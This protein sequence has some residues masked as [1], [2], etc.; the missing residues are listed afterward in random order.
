MVWSVLFK[1]VM[2]QYLIDGLRLE[3]YQKLKK[4]FN[5]H[6]KASPFGTIFWIELD[7]DILTDLQ[8]EHKAC[9]P[10]VFAAE[11][12]E[13]YLSCELLVRITKNIKCDCMGY[14]TVQQ[15]NWLIEKVDAILEELEVS[16]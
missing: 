14:A 6:F 16:I 2:K 11:L 12:E 1:S 3:D 15:R 13:E 4:Y 8:K 7:R 10:H 5:G 9:K